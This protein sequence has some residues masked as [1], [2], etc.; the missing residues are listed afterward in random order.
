V[1]SNNERT[2]IYQ[3]VPGKSNKNIGLNSLTQQVPHKKRI[4]N[5]RN[6]LD[7]N[8]SRHESNP[9]SYSRSRSFNT[10]VIDN[11]TI[12]STRTRKD[13]TEIRNRRADYYAIGKN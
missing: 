9:K 10:Y 8:S 7:G 4:K 5:S 6:N 13:S 11:K 12:G 1:Y 2:N 3:P